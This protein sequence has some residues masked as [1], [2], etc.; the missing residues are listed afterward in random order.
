M[1]CSKL[2]SLKNNGISNTFK[3]KEP[4]IYSFFN[5]LIVFIEVLLPHGVTLA[6]VY[7][8]VM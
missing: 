6:Q 3:A 8:V 2:P 5:F 4:T 1:L 7:S